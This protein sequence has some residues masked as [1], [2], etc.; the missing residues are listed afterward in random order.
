VTG[1]KSLAQLLAA[2]ALILVFSSFALANSVAKTASKNVVQSGTYDVGI[3]PSSPG[4]CP[5]G[6]AYITMYGDDEDSNN[7]SSI[8]GW[9]GAFHEHVSSHVDGTEFGFCR[10]DGSHLY[11]LGHYALID[12][13][14]NAPAKAQIGSY[15][16][17]V[18]K[19]G[20]DCP[21]GSID[22]T[23]NVDNED[24]NNQDTSNGTIWPSVVSHNM[25]LK[26]CMFT[27]S[28]AGYPHMGAFPD[29][30]ISYGVLAGR[31]I[32]PSTLGHHNYW[33]KRGTAVTDDED[34]NN[35]DGPQSGGQT[36]N[37]KIDFG[38]N[39]FHNTVLG[40]SVSKTTFYIAEVRLN[41]G[42]PAVLWNNSLQS[43]T[44]VGNRCFVRSEP[45]NASLFIYANKYYVTPTPS[46]NCP[47]G[48]WDGAHCFVQQEPSGGF[49]WHNGF[50]V[51]AG[52]GNSCPA[53]FTYDGAH[54]YRPPPWGT[55]AF[56]WS[57]NFYTTTLPSCID[58]AYD[59]AN[60]YIGKPP[61]DTTAFILSH[62]FYY[63]Q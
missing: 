7:Q 54:C 1:S 17:S 27:P 35:Q 13:L 30:G 15:T 42:Q 28:A 55:T 61:V 60:C 58:G 29:Y 53:N 34:H 51:S 52:A 8:T 47:I 39:V 6:S 56:A 24:N 4:L 38:N 44:L 19:L 11:N 5:S 57:G 37:N 63:T 9:V 36:L 31:N 45:M 46:Q 14:N 59:G 43:A 21:N 49:I 2:T 18:L 50:Y 33:I 41:C 40:Y 16:Y 25:S 32:P 12:W 3:I 23:Y 10:V 26:F 48:T 20:T 62:T 22:F